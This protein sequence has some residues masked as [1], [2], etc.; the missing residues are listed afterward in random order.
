[1]SDWNSRRIKKYYLGSDKLYD[2]LINKIAGNDNYFIY[3]FI[4]HLRKYEYLISFNSSSIILKLKRLYHLNRYQ[5]YARILGYV[6]GDGVLGDNVIFF[7]RASIIINAQA[8]IG[9]G[10]QFHG[11]AVIGVKNT[12]SKGC[13]VLGK[14]VDIGAGAV[15]LGDIYIADDVV[16]GANSVVIHSVKTPGTVVAGVPAKE[17]RVNNNT[18]S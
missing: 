18:D 14:N 5:K 8:R 1:M 4:Y 17:I 3:K 7:H 11:D 15:I 16:I 10:C 12:G 6:I 13:P 2:Y 9:D